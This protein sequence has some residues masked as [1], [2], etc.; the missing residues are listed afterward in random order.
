[1]ILEKV[2]EAVRN[3]EFQ[4]LTPIF[5]NFLDRGF[6]PSFVFLQEELELMNLHAEFGWLNVCPEISKLLIT[7]YFFVKIFIYQSVGKR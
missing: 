7:V 5:M 6:P 2:E 3:G 4:S 1:M